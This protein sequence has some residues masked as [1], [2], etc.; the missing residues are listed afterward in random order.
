MTKDPRASDG[1]GLG[2]M[3]YRAGIIGATFALRTAPEEGTCITCRLPLESAA[4]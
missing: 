2:I 4:P 3:S 1:M